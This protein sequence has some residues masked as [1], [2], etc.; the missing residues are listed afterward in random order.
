MTEKTASFWQIIEQSGTDYERAVAMLSEKSLSFI[1]DFEEF[2]AQK[3]YALDKK[4]LAEKIY[5]DSSVSKDDF[6]YVRC[7]TLA[8]GKTYFEKVL[9]GEIP[10]LNRT[11]EALISLSEKAYLRKTNAEMPP[12][13]TSVSYE[14]GSNREEW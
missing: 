12:F 7:Y 10:M 4:R 2:L 11:F 3:L 5:K 9:A 14:T 8:Q 1:F 13:V 6:L